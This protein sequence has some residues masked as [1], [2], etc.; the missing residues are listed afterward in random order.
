MEITNLKNR[1]KRLKK[2]KYYEAVV[3]LVLILLT[4]YVGH[5]SFENNPS[6]PFTPKSS[7]ISGQDYM[8]TYLLG[9]CLGFLVCEFM[10]LGKTRLYY[11]DYKPKMIHKAIENARLNDK[12]DKDGNR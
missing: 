12:N 6:K 9:L 3:W 10:W 4:A 2:Y 7:Y 5:A 11:E 1:S 8:I